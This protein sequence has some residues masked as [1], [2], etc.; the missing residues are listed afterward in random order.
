MQVW[1]NKYVG[2]PYKHLGT[3]PKTGIDCF[4]L[5]KLI[6]KERLDIDIPYTT[7]DFCNIQD[8]T[9]WYKG[10][11]DFPMERAATQQYGWNRIEKGRT[12]SEVLQ[13]YDLV[14]MK[15]GSTNCVNHCAIVVD[16]VGKY[17]KLL[18]TMMDNPDG[19]WVAPYGKSYESNYTELVVRW[20][21]L[22]N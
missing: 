3:D 2:L 18:H 12:W 4:N 7:N 9:A 22:N 1:Y 20:I 5:C 17:K 19:S 16:T 6:Y 13:L 11:T 21:G 14:L 10:F 8:A 15:M